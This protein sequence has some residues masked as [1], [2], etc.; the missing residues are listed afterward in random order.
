MLRLLSEIHNSEKE[1]R[2]AAVK[3]L[4]ELGISEDRLRYARLLKHPDRASRLRL[5]S[6][7]SDVP[8]PLRT[9]LWI[10]LMVD[11]D[12]HI[13]EAAIGTLQ[14]E[15][16]KGRT[17]E[18]LKTLQQTERNTLVLRQIERLLNADHVALDNRYEAS[19]R[20]DIVRLCPWIV[21]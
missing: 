20:Y 15:H 21:S 7:L 13:R 19:K 14:K 2:E 6:Q 8:E 5:V 18:R 17:G 12:S 16:I 3:E 4:Y 10:E 9:D 11:P 1:T